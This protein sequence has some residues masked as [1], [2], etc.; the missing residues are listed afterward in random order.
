MTR[1]VWIALAVIA[2]VVA[3][4][5]LVALPRGQEWSTS[6]PEALAEFES[7]YDAQRKVY[8]QEAREHYR[9][10]YEIDPEFVMAKLRYALALSQDDPEAAEELFAELMEAETSGL[11]PREK[12]LIGRWRANRE[13]RYDE[14][15]RLLEEYHARYPTDPYI[16]NVRAGIAWNRGELDEAARLYQELLGVDSNWVTA[17]NALGYI[18]MMQERFVESEEHFKHYRYI[19]PDQ[20]N[21]HDSLGELYI[22]TGRYGEAEA[23]LERAIEI[24]HDFWASYLHLAIMNAYVGNAEDGRAVIERARAAGMP[25]AAVAEMECLA[26]Y[27]ELVKREAWQRI[28]DER[29]TEC[30]ADVRS[31]YAVVVTHRAASRLGDWETV[32]RIEDDAAGNLLAA[33]SDGDEGDTVTLRAVLHHMQGVRMAIQGDLAAAAERFQGADDRLTFI[34]VDSGMFKLLNRLFLVETLRA[35]RKDAEAHKQLAW[36]RNIN[37]V[38]VAEFETSGFRLLG[39]GRG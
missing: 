10:A 2:M 12:F 34:R 14:A 23:S 1:W 7:G 5:T 4:V 25:E 30:V 8:F 35:G 6:S 15:A 19:A 28:L 24:K 39:L 20:A 33:E 37:P 38:M 18:S 17:Y 21:P 29:S 27:S 16:L 36:V 31:G 13:G 9:Q 11:S 22:T 26:H 32:Q 3:G